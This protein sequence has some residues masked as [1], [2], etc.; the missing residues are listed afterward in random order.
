MKRGGL[1]KGE[2]KR[3][4]MGKVEEVVSCVELREMKGENCRARS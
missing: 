1:K 3:G 2:G 4:G